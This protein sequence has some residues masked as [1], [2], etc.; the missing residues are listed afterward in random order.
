VTVPNGAALAHRSDDAE[1]RKVIVLAGELDGKPSRPHPPTSQV[2]RAS[3]EQIDTRF[4]PSWDDPAEY[5][6][7]VHCSAVEEAERESLRH[8]LDKWGAPS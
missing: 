7:A 4:T 1:G 3:T 5:V 6:E 8:V 2:L